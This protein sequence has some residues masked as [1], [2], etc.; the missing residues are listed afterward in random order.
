MNMNHTIVHRFPA[1]E[2]PVSTGQRTTCQPCA[3]GDCRRCTVYHETRRLINRQPDD[4]RRPVPDTVCNHNC[5][6]LRGRRPQT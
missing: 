6:P 2:K 5:T 3:T 4:T 1:Y